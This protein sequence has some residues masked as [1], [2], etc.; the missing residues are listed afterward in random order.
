MLELNQQFFNRIVY[1]KLYHSERN[2]ASI[3]IPAK[4]LKIENFQKVLAF[5]YITGLLTKKKTNPC[6]ME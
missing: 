5:F 3:Y 6:S 4:R 1:Q 2:Q